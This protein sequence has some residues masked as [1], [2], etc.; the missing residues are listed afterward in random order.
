MCCLC[1]VVLPV[2]CGLLVACWEMAGLL[3]FPLC[4]VLL[5]FVTFPYCDPDQVWRLIVSIPDLCI[6]LFL[7]SHPP[8]E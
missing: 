4:G 3:A 1:F 2:T 5:C 6:V 8:I 7:I